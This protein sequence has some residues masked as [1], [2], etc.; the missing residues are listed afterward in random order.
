MPIPQD[1]LPLGRTLLRNNVYER[2]RDALVDGTFAPGEQLKD[3]ELA[4]WLGVSRTPVREALLRLAASGLVVAQPGRSTVVSLIDDRKVRDARDVV[5]SM[6]QLA[7]RQT[8][9]SQS[10][11]S[12]DLDRMRSANRDFAAAIEAGDVNAALDADEAFHAVPVTVLGN[13]ALASVLSQFS[14]VVR[15]VERLRFS[16]SGAASVAA[17][18]RLIELCAAG[19]VEAAA[20]V[21]YDTWHSLPVDDGEEQ[22]G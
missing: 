22:A 20:T 13:E 18:D 9:E 10:L 12:D 4:T 8:V 2:L 11:D 14:P 1:A 7:V 17:H 3:G 19:N 21:A 6:H 16:S 5:A 15:R